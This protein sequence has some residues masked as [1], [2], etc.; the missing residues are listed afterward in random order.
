MH[1]NNKALTKLTMQ[2]AKERERDRQR[3]REGRKE[4]AGSIDGAAF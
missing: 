2:T 3:E 4:I 1:K